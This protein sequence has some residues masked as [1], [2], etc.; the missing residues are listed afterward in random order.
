[1]NHEKIIVPTIDV[2]I[3]NSTISNMAVFVFQAGNVRNVQDTSS[4]H[5]HQV[6]DTRFCHSIA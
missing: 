3:S 2:T 4:L 6:A 1:M 5:Y